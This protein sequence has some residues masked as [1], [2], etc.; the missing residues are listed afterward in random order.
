MFGGARSAGGELRFACVFLPAL[1]ADPAAYTARALRSVKSALRL[2]PAAALTILTDSATQI[3]PELPALRARLRRQRQREMMQ[4]Q[5][6]QLRD[7]E[8][9]DPP[10]LLP[11]PPPPLL[12]DDAGAPPPPQPPPR[13]VRGAGW[14]AP[15][16]KQQLLSGSR[17][18]P[19]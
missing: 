8:D 18:L 14:R 6:Q 10:P 13:K 15:S 5:Q 3:P 16:R 7:D 9:D 17:R 2:H 1:A 4:Q 11:P 19:N 12:N